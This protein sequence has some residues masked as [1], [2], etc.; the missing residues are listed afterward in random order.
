MGNE[1]KN[2][3]KNDIF[4]NPRLDVVMQAVDL[5]K[6]ILLLIERYFELSHSPKQFIP[7]KSLIPVSGKVYDETDIQMLVASSLDFWLTADRFNE[8]FE[9][10]LSEFLQVKFSITTNSG[11]SANLLA[12][13]ALTSE[14]LEDKALKPGDEVITT[15]AGF[16][17]TV[18]PILQNNLIPVFVDVDVSTYVPSIQ[19]IGEAIS[20]KTKAIILAHTL[21]NAYDIE[22]I[23]NIAKKH[24]LWV[25]EDCCDAL[26]TTFKGKP[27][28]TFGDLGTLSFYPAHHI[29][30]GEG[31]AVFTNNP[32]LKR[33]VESFRDWG[34]DCFCAPG[35]S[36]TCRKRFEWKLGD[37]PFG[38][39]HKY[40]YSHTGYNLKITD[41]QAAIGLSQ[42]KHLPKFITRRKENFEF[43]KKNLDKHKKYLILPET[44]KNSDPAWFGFPITVRK[45]APFS[46]D[47][48]INFL[49]SKLIDTRPLFAGNITKQPYFKNKHYRI[50]KNLD[51]TDLIMSNTFWIGVFPGLT[52]EMLS[53]ITEQIDIFINTVESKN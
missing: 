7:G 44:T 14:Q 17:T 6:Q 46:K 40:T 47:H 2:L 8:K 23:V 32:T 42:L 9:K 39:D 12:V 20:K 13:S 31:G 38:Y 25:I 28:G 34:R 36:N 43:L 37:L 4:F 16:P 24:E 27:V 21:G 45:D 19:S 3:E 53:Y 49:S 35:K 11:S 50:H 1:M 5:R 29:T 22:S 48:I 51:N 33:I 10:Q 15:A 26:G 30:M 52:V 41:M 18:N